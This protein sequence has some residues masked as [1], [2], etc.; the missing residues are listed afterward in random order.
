MGLHSIKA[1]PRATQILSVLALLFAAGCRSLAPFP[2][3]DLSQGSWQVRQGQAV[4]RPNRAAP[5]IAGEILLATQPGGRSLV[6][7]SKTPFT[8]ALAQVAPESWQIEFPAQKRRVTAPGAPPLTRAWP[9]SKLPLTFLHVP[10]CLDGRSLG[11]NWT[12]RH[13]VEG[14]FRLEN[15]STGESLEGY[16]DDAP[17]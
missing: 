11:P 16:L 13:S 15:V 4:W 9:R 7:F 3:T 6:Q 1:G 14:T 2:P 5:E 17:K 8:I 12:S 10:A